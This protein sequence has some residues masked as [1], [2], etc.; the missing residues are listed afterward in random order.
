MRVS[1]W[2][3]LVVAVP[4]LGAAGAVLLV[5]RL[6]PEIKG[7]GVPEVLE[8]IYYAGGKIRAV[9]APAKLLASSLLSCSLR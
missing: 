5:R 1:P 2:G 4:V 3:P 8:A 7:A 6:A 9:V